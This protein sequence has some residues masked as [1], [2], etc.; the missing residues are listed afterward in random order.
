MK[1]YEVDRKN[2]KC[3]CIRFS[4]SGISTINTANSQ[5]YLNIPR[6]HSLVSSLKNYLDSNFDVIDAATNNRYVDGDDIWL[7]NLA[8][9]ALFSNFNLTTTSGKH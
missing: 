7:I 2:L 1:N 6:E 5:L 8:L 3:D 4:P 9:N